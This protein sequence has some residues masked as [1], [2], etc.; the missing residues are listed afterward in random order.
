MKTRLEVLLGT[1]RAKKVCEDLAL[2]LAK[3]NLVHSPEICKELFTYMI[4]VTDDWN[5][6]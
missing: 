3:H 4:S 1:D 5:P 2:V 6:V